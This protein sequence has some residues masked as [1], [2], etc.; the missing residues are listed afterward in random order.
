[1]SLVKSTALAAVVLSCLAGSA[2]A[3]WFHRMWSSMR[4]DFRRNNAWPYTF[5]YDDIQA[6]NAPFDVMIYN[7][8][9]V[10]N[11]LGPHYFEE[12]TTDLTEAGK[13]KIQWIMTE[14]PEQFR[15]VFV[16]RSN[17]RA[18]TAARIEAVRL[19]ATESLPEGVEAEVVETNLPARG[20]PAEYINTVNEK[21]KA[22]MPDPRLPAPQGDDSGS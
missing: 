16:E 7:G 2:H 6:A 18:V 5:V 3:D 9:R 4:T 20:T 8:W 1:M 10:Q 11:T 14:A 17:N 15:T 21:Y 13:L 19:A 12:G 22:S